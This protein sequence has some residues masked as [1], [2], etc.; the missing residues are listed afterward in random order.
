M[1]LFRREPTAE[2]RLRRRTTQEVF[3][4]HLALMASGDPAADLAR[5]YSDHS[6][7]LTSMG[8]FRGQHG[9]RS[10]GDWIHT[11]VPFAELEIVTRLVSGEVAF[12]EWN[13]R[14]RHTEI[15][16]GANSYLIRDGRI[17]VQT[18]HFLVVPR[19]S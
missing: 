18:V 14:S 8:V 12:L 1:R 6:I 15:T 9:R 5:N 13:A 3:D 2:E 17:L 11:K 16:S 10:L 7:V 19:G 4:D